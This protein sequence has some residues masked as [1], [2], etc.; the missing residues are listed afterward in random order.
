VTEEVLRLQA[1][2]RELR[3]R[4]ERL[5]SLLF[6]LLEPIPEEDLVV[7]AAAVAAYCGK[8]TPIR[9]IRLLGNKSWAI[10]GRVSLQASHDWS[11]R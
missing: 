4:V 7:L 9:Q 5:E 2:V 11:H 3:K 6:E 10:Q 8:R 1:E